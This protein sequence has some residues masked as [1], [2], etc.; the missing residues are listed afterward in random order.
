MFST[1]KENVI[2]IANCLAL[3]F[4]YL[5]F[6]MYV[7]FLKKKHAGLTILAGLLA[8]AYS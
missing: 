6:K 4:F 2:L 5:N 3:I 7:F 1:F 8:E